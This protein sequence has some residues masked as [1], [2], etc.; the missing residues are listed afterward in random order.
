VVRDAQDFQDVLERQVEKARNE[1]S[2]SEHARGEGLACFWLGESWHGV[3]SSR[4][5]PEKTVF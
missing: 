5:I 4:K 2:Q 1:L 3:A